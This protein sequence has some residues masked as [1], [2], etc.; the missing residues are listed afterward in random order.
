MI[1]PIKK[2]IPEML[3]EIVLIFFITKWRARSPLIYVE[4]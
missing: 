4:R 3:I 2:F 1:L